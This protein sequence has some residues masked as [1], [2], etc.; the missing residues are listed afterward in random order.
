MNLRQLLAALIAGCATSAT[1]QYGYMPMMPSDTMQHVYTAL[2]WDPNESGWGLN[3]THQGNIV[4]ATLF[5][6]APDGQPMWLVASSLDGMADYGMG[7]YGMGMAPTTSYSG[8]L[9]RTTGTPFYQQPWAPIGFRQVGSMSIMYTSESAGMLT[10]TV[11][12]V[13]VSKSIQRQVFAAPVPMCEAVDGSR[14]YET[15][16][17]DLWWNSN[18]SGWGLNI[19]HQGNTIFATIFTYSDSGR[20]MWFVASNVARQADGSFAG[21]LF[22]TTGPA[23]N[24]VPWKAIEVAR[25]GNITLAFSDGEHGTLT[26]TVGTRTV[27][28]AITRQVF[29]A[30]TSA[31]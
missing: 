6:Y 9:Y 23:F 3:T 4:F 8:A 30:M 7:D 24:A 14:A 13:V 18:E 22:D 15:N 19:V 21:D 25:V 17:Q 2:W 29:Q 20:D 26:Y 27:V 31:C 16:Y 11:D 5:T 12:G 28:K 10:Y 1:A